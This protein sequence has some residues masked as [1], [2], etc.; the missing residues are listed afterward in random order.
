[1]KVQNSDIVIVNKNK[2]IKYILSESHP[3]G[4]WK[5]LFFKNMDLLPVMLTY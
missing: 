1:M 2:L 3:I 5:A 4:K